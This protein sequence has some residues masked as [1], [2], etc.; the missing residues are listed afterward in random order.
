V[1]SVET[2]SEPSELRE[3]KRLT[4]AAALAV[5][6]VAGV[7]LALAFPEPDIAPL[8][9]F[10]IAPLLWLAYGAGARRGFALG[11]AFGIGFF[12]VLI[13]W[14]SIIGFIGFV[15]LV[16]L[17]AAFIGAFAAVWGWS[18]ARV[19]IAGRILV[20]AVLWVAIV[21]YARS[22]LLVVGFTWGELAQSQHDFPWQ[23]K[24]ASIGG[25]WAIAF[26][27]VVAN[28]AVVESFRAGTA[29]RWPAA[30]V[31]AAVGVVAIV[32]PVI[33]PARRAGGETVKIAIVQGNIPR[34]MAAS[35]EKDLIIL[36]SH[37]HLTEELPDD[38][39]LVVWPESSVGIDPF[40]N[41]EVMEAISGAAREAGAPMIV[42][43][44]LE[45]D[46][47]KYQ[48]MAYLV[49]EDGEFIDRYQKT[50][51]VPF[52]EYVPARGIFGWIPA[53]DQVGRDA[54][55]GDERTIFS[56]AGGTVAPVISFEGDF[57]SLVRGRVDVGGKMVVVAT[58]T[59]TWEDSWASAQ[60]LAMSE[61][62]AAENGVFVV[63]AAL[64]GI[65][66]FVDPSGAVLGRTE[67]WQQSVLIRDVRFALGDEVAN[68]DGVSFYSRTGDWLPIGCALA[69]LGWIV[70]VVTRRRRPGTVP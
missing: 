69:T 23:L 27:L 53:L 44:N 57:G 61:V 28:A 65:S 48:V 47:G 17:Q 20:P 2:A 12:S 4:G 46:D 42:G 21:E 35:F 30:A 13:Y 41:P 40:R 18:S 39:D 60:H 34:E 51:L 66:A 70:L 54:V 10:S 19:P 37:V 56:V 62:R 43:G 9:W 52:G 32:G 6:A 29:R 36:Q 22:R 68:P 50:H 26:L 59:S 1:G 3:P 31:T 5:V 63:H 7:L 49:S 58:N 33:V 15:V 24:A 8:A 64:T 55:P 14:I 45:R 16:L 11:M 38:V 25:G 67:L